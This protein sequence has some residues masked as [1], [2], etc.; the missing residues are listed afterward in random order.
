MSEN[1]EI[2]YGLVDIDDGHLYQAHYSVKAT[3]ELN[4]IILMC[5]Q[6]NK[7]IPG[8]DDDYDGSYG[9]VTD[10]TVIYQYG[11]LYPV[12][13]ADFPMFDPFENPYANPDNGEFD[14]FSQ[15]L[16]TRDWYIKPCYT[17]KSYDAKEV[18]CY[19]DIETALYEARYSAKKI[20]KKNPHCAADIIV[21][22]YDPSGNKVGYIDVN[23][24][25]HK[26][27]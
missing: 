25:A 10:G 3:N 9:Y 27:K 20:C 24:T 4:A 21:T 11:G 17:A 6:M 5:K 26:Y 12:K 1:T 7:E 13:N 18:G 19:A 15:Y 22:V 2:T 8:E 14:K 23:G 16:C